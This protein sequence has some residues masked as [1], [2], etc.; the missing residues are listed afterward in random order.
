MLRFPKSS[1]YGLRIV[2]IGNS[3][4]ILV[5][6]DL[7]KHFELPVT[8]Y[9]LPATSYQLPASSYHV[10]ATSYQVPATKY[11]NFSPTGFYVILWMTGV[12][13]LGSIFLTLFVDCEL[14]CFFPCLL[15]E[16]C[17]VFSFFSHR[18]NK[19]CSLFSVEFWTW[20]TLCLRW[21]KMKEPS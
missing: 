2:S 13:V 21:T 15:N 12:K 14:K 9:Q 20:V 4:L 16:F 3:L 19:T 6:I 5:G 7:N 8:T 17:H 10:P 1:F 18:N 11:Q